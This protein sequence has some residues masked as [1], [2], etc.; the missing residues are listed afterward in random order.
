MTQHQQDRLAFIEAQIAKY[1]SQIDANPDDS[2]SDT[3]REFQANIHY[4]KG[5]KEEVE[6]AIAANN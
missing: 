1:Q 6:L 2:D 3:Y 5:R 4:W